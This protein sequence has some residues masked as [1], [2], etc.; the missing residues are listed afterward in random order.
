[1]QADVP[2]EWDEKC[3]AFA[4]WIS[5]GSV[6]EGWDDEKCSAFVEWIRDD[7]NFARRH[8]RDGAPRLL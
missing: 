7:R 8:A 3:N 6:P 1:M 2:E 5:D 4:M